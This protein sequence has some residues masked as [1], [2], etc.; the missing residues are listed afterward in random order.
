[1]QVETKKPSSHLNLTATTSATTTTTKKRT[2]R[3]VNDDATG[4]G[5]GG[6]GGAYREEYDS[7]ED[8][9]IDTQSDDSGTEDDDVAMNNASLAFLKTTRSGRTPIARTFS[10]QPPPLSAASPVEQS[11]AVAAELPVA[12][13]EVAGKSRRRK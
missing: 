12:S 7:D 9:D 10:I 13:T 6:G 11:S 4:G 1:V 2:A 5:G 8:D 3:A